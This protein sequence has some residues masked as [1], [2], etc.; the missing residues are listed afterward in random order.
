[1]HIEKIEVGRRAAEVNQVVERVANVAIRGLD[2][3]R[4]FFGGHGRKA[5]Y[6]DAHYEFVGGERDALRRKHYDK[7]L[8]LLW[9]AEKHAPWSTFLDGADDLPLVK[10]ARESMTK[11]ERAASKKLASKEFKGR[12]AREYTLAERQAL[13]KVLCAIGHG[14]AYAWLVSA[15]VLAD[16]QSTGARAAL[17]MQV[18]EEAKHF[19]VLRELIKAFDVGVPRQSAWE[20]LLLEQV[21]KADGL[22]KLFGMNVLVEGIALSIFGMLAHFPGLEILRLFHLDESRH[23][24][25]PVNYFKE[26]PLDRWERVNP[27]K[28]MKRLN[29]VLPA[30]PLVFYL[31]APL[32]ELGIDAL[33]LGGS[34]IRKVTQLAERA[35]FE[36]RGSG[37]VL[38]MRLNALF[39]AYGSLTR[40]HHQHRDYHLGDTTRDAAAR[41]VE[42]EV[43]AA[44]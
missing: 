8:K 44:A 18:V 27:L 6:D 9:K 15:E 4:A 21:L 11:A 36:P 30:I 7:S 43:F 22:D 38:G 17:T 32:A 12:L 2:D 26:F 10:M 24:A 19:V 35:G 34:V 3:T 16:V 14:E 40:P 25:L 29:L 5:R 39:N 42:D 31:E 23:T 41:A 28:R 20:Y 13:V 1:M 37:E 33:A